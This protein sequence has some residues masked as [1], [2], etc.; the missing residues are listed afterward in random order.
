MFDSLESGKVNP[1]AH[2]D[3]GAATTEQ[4]SRSSRHRAASSP[5]SS[6]PARTLHR[7]PPT[8][9]SNS[10]TRSEETKQIS[11]LVG[12]IDLLHELGLANA[13]AGILLE[14][15]MQHDREL[16]VDLL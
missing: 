9:V 15:R 6:L 2:I 4:P 16:A 1:R 5:N 10:L 3:H 12:D 13:L 14:V 11:G 7:I 8:T